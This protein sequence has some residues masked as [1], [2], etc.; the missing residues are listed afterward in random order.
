MIMNGLERYPGGCTGIEMDVVNHVVRLIME[1][2]AY[3]YSF[4]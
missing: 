4:P 3:N 1:L 2:P